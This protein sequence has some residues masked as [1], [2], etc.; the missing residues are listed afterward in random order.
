MN[1]MHPIHAHKDIGYEKKKKVREIRVTEKAASIS[2][3][4]VIAER[5]KVHGISDS[6][7][8]NAK[9][10]A[11]FI[12]NLRKIYYARGSVPSKVAVQNINLTIPQGEIFGLLG[13]NGAGKTTLLK[14]VSGLELPTSGF[15]L[16]NG[17]DV[18]RNTSQA[19]R[20]MGLCPQFDTLIERLSVRENLIF[21][22]KI[23][24]LDS[25]QVIPVT[26]AF[27][28]AMSIKRYEHKL[29]Q[30]LSGGNRRKVSLAVALMGAP[31]TVYLDEPST[32][33][34]PVACR[35]MW[36][37]LSK[38]SSAKNTAIVLTTHNMLE[39]EAVCTR[40]CIMKLGQMVCLGDSQHLRSTHG[41]GFQLEMSLKVPDA[42]E[43]IKQFVE[44]NFT[45]AVL[46]EVHSMMLNYE[47]PRES[48]TKLSKAFKLLQDNKESLGIEDYVLSQSTLE[49]VFLKQIRVNESDVSKLADQNDMD[50]RVPE[51][52]DYF[53][54]YCVWLL[55]GAIP[56][57]HHFYLGNFWRGV[58]YLFTLNEAIAGWLLDLSEMHVLVQKS[59]Q[60]YGHTRGTCTCC[61]CCDSRC[62]SNGHELPMDEE[63][64]SSNV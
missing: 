56:G 6:G 24:G 42:A 50:K 16:I 31:P 57:L 35:L 55:A 36:R 17:H 64:N 38:I 62:C 47:I 27:L 21:F 13:A 46:I 1:E 58:K 9:Q 23:K 52:R 48:I 29:V 51:F 10:N 41:T 34:D 63:D 25:D 60:E 33:L 4:D 7:V 44:N 15:A 37:L 20:S 59:V 39:C 53:N 54:A 45:G 32:G 28:A 8:L 11:I 30:Q 43:G 22:G 19:Q 5:E 12:C 18:V 49:Q 61:L 26:E 3:P 14:M 40:V 2:D